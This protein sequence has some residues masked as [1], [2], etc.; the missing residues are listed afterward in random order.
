VA[1]LEKLTAL[2]GAEAMEPYSRFSY[3]VGDLKDARTIANFYTGL[4]STGR[5]SFDF[6]L[7]LSEHAG[8]EMDA[9]H[10][11]L[12]ALKL[13]GVV[14]QGLELHTGLHL[15]AFAMA[16]QARQIGITAAGLEPESSA[17]RWHWKA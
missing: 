17:V 9:L 4:K 7:D 3:L 1:V 13:M 14:V 10:E 12:D 2:P 15:P 6:E 11:L 16:L 8:L 5:Q